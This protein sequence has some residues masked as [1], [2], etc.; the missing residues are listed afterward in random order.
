MHDEQGSPVVAKCSRRH[1]SPAEQ[2]FLEDPVTEAKIL[3]LLGAHPRLV[4]FKRFYSNKQYDV[5]LT[6]YMA[7]GDL[8]EWTRRHPPDGTEQRE[9]LVRRFVR[10]VTEGLCYLQDHQV[11]HVDVSLENIFLDENQT[12]ACLGD[13]GLARV[14]ISDQPWPAFT[15]CRPGK[16]FYMAPEVALRQVISH[17]A[18]VDVWSLGICV[19]MLLTEFP[20]YDNPSFTGDPRYRLL[21]EKGIQEVVRIYDQYF[22]KQHGPKAPVLE[23]VRISSLGMDFLQKTLVFNPEKRTTVQA[24]LQHPWLIL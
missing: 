2:T 14:Y 22:L 5:V 6:A 13:F 16:L 11:S 8:Y 17:P 15:G 4:P 3:S 21:H 12:A 19:F 7:G 18:A 1:R 10:H 9:L 23:G 20:P 24:L